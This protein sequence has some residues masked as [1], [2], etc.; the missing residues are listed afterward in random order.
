MDRSKVA[1]IIPAHNE[2]STIADI[3]VKSS[4]YGVPIVVDDSS[5]DNTAF[6]ARDNGA[7]VISHS[8]Q[9]GYD[10]SLNSG[11]LEANKRNF[12]IAITIDADGQHSPSIIPN[13]IQE[14]SKDVDLV[15]GIRPK[16]QRFSERIF[17]FYTRIRFGLIDPL[18][19]MKC[20][21]M[22]LYK[23]LGSFDT[24]TSI[25]T[26]LTIFS[27]KRKKNFKQIKIPILLN[28]KQSAFGF[29]LKSDL[30]ILRSMFLSLRI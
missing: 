22:D 30:K 19:G 10:S 16:F 6:I 21:N 14:I 11:F 24:Y 18:C 29:S 4:I 28:R 8:S 25:G 20:Y 1:I 12:F 26:Q 15:V 2:E 7:L 23:A 13:F 17:S 27:L 5:I 3:V 9:L